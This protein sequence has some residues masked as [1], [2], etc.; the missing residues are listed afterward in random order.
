MWRHGDS[1]TVEA[2]LSVVVSGRSDST[3]NRMGV[4]MGSADT[5]AVVEQLSGIADSFVV[6]VEQADGG[7]F[8]PLFVVTEDGGESDDGLRERITAAI[9]HRLSPRHVP[10][11]I[12]RVPALPRTLTGKRLEVPV[13]RL[14]QGANTADVTGPGAVTDGHM[15]DWFAAFGARTNGSGNAWTNVTGRT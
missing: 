8:M 3:L 6:G 13:K 14:L 2:D 15:L 4:R 7:Y 5:Y 10:D 11:V 9:R 12:V 1:V